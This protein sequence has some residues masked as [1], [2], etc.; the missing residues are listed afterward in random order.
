VMMG[1]QLLTLGTAVWILLA[2]RRYT[3]YAISNTSAVRNSAK[4]R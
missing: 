2:Q 4:A 3:R 1:E